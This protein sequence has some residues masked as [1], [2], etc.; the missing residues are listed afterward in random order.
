[1]NCPNSVLSQEKGGNVE[2]QDPIPDQPLQAH[3]LVAASL[4]P[5]APWNSSP[6]C[7]LSFTFVKNTSL[8]FCRMSH[9]GFV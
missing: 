2:V 4:V 9:F 5:P 3:E 6:V 1:M 8:V 7:L